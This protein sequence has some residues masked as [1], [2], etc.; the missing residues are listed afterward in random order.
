MVESNG[1]PQDNSVAEP[2]SITET[3]CAY[4]AKHLT[5]RRDPIDALRNE[6]LFEVITPAGRFRMSRGD[7]YTQFSEVAN[8]SSYRQLGEYHYPMIPY[9]AFRFLVR[10]P[11]AATVNKSGF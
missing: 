2:V 4:E 5:F 11:K 8:S 7:F 6:E 3:A 10:E 1:I 9:K